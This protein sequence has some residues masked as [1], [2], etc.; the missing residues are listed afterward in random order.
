MCRP[1]N[2]F[3]SLTANKGVVG[4]LRALAPLAGIAADTGEASVD[5]AVA[6]IHKG[7]AVAHHRL[8]AE[9]NVGPQ[10]HNDVS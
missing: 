5:E 9:V 8:E 2:L 6:T 10:Q 3:T 1:R 7:E 4:L